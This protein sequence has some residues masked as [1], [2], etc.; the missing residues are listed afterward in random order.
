[1]S[2]LWRDEVSIG[3]APDRIE[4]VRRERGWKPRIEHASVLELAGVK[5]DGWRAGIAALTDALTDP[6][7]QRAQCRI[8]ISNHFVRYAL[9]DAPPELANDEEREA[10]VN[11][12]YRAIYGDRANS[13]QSTFAPFGPGQ[14]SVAC[15]VE[16]AMLDALRDCAT[17]ARLALASAQPYLVAAFNGVS[18]IVRGENVWFVTV[19]HGRIAAAAFNQDRWAGIRNEPVDGDIGAAL[20]SLLAQEALGRDFGDAGRQAYLHA[21]GWSGELVMPGEGW[22]LHRID[23][24]TWPNSAS[25]DPV[26]F[27]PAQFPLTLSTA[28]PA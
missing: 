26:D 4:L 24:A 15:A 18:A 10:F 28:L 25:H 7:W 16:Q 22:T 8:V 11:L 1:M 6:R 3:F 12:R 19:E 9:I 27:D 23:T 21:P 5:G 2:L 17:A 14:R 13:W 20:S